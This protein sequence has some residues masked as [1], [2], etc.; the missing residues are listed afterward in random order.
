MG[1]CQALPVHEGSMA[2][3]KEASSRRGSFGFLFLL[4]SSWILRTWRRW[5]RR[6]PSSASAAR[7]HCIGAYR[8]RGR[9][10]IKVDGVFIELVKLD[11]PV[12]GL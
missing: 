9:N 7:N 3:S 10:L 1:Q 5:R 4:S 11:Y 6:S 8:K 2:S 12:Q